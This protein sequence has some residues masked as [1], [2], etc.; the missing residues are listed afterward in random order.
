MSEEHNYRFDLETLDSFPGSTKW[1]PGNGKRKSAKKIRRPFFRPE[2]FFLLDIWGKGMPTTRNR[3]LFSKGVGKPM[4]MSEL[5]CMFYFPS[6]QKK[7]EE[8][9]F[10]N[11]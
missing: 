1:V 5:K 3:L 7:R 4:C 11:A 6:N 9:T 10:L 2:D 8:K